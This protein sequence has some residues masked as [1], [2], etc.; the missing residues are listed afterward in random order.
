MFGRRH[1]SKSNQALFNEDFF[2]LK[3]K[4]CVNTKQFSNSKDAFDI[5]LGETGLWTPLNTTNNEI[6]SEVIVN[7]LMKEYIEY[8]ELD[9]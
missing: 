6:I 1:L 9:K 4:E 2:A 7:K 3:I 5:Y 8:K